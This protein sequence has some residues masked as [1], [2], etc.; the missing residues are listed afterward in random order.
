MRFYFFRGGVVYV[1]NDTKQRLPKHALSLHW[2]QC[3]GCRRVLGS[4]RPHAFEILPSSFRSQHSFS[5]HNSP[6]NNIP[7]SSCVNFPSFQ[8]AAAD[9]YEASDWLQAIVQAA[10]SVSKNLFI[11]KLILKVN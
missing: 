1:F 7:L 2:D 6:H 3:G 5:N 8:L 11:Y 9:D 4:P 10:S